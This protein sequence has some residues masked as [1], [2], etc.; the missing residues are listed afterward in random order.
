MKVTVKIWDALNQ[1]REDA[2]SVE[3]ENHG[4]CVLGTDNTWLRYE[5]Q[6]FMEKNWANN[7]YVSTMY[8]NVETEAGR[9]LEFEVFAAPTV[10]F[11]AIPRQ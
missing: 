8:V 3:F 11:R 2:K 9:F 10:T 4:G 5:V 6:G 1:E 7:D